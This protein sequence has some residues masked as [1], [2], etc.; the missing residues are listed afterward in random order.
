MNDKQVVIGIFENE[1]CAVVARRDLRFAGIKANIVKE[2]GGVTL[3]LLQQAEGIQIL[4]PET[5]E[6][7]AKE[8]L[9]SKFY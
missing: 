9:Q 7:I 3:H 6:K 1:L 5:Q 2:G 4:V 8:I